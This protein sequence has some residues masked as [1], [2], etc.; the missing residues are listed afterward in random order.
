LLSKSQNHFRVIPSA[1]SSSKTLK[2]KTSLFSLACASAAILASANSGLYEVK[3]MGSQKFLHPMTYYQE[4]FAEWMAL[5]DVKFESAEEQEQALLNFSEADDF[6]E[7][8]NSGSHSYSLGHNQFSHLSWDQ[9]RDH[10]GIGVPMLERKS[11]LRRLPKNLRAFQVPES[12]DWRDEG[13][14]TTVKNQE[15]CGSCWSF[16]AT[17]AI[18]GAY[19]LKNGELVSFSEQMLVDCDYED[20]GCNG[21]LMDNAFE[22]I[23]D[24]GGL[25]SEHAYPY[26]AK[27]ESCRDW[28]CTPVSHS[29]PT[30]WVDIDQSEKALMEAVAQTPVAIAIEA[31]QMAFQFYS[32]G[33]FTGSC[34]TSLDHG[35]LA[36]G[37]GK[38]ES[39]QEYWIVKNS[40]GDSWGKDG[41]IYLEKG[42]DQEGGQCGLY[43]QASYP[44]MP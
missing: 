35:V 2:M 7:T 44:E 9:F 19:F 10:K 6:I 15:Q 29:N 33:V 30:G 43:L 32:D 8:H 28:S 39:G 38:D 34:G 4:K 21:G 1:L 31:D 13:A 24:N 41:Y 37:Y 42:K 14:V 36:V 16:S 3:E 11:P 18:E 5:Y 40:W 20:L 27:K 26:I 12:K 22:W 23:E 17:G 25:C